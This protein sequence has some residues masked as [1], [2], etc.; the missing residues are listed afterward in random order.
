MIEMNK[1]VIRMALRSVKKGST[2]RVLYWLG[3]RH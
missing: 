2:L 3:M 1:N